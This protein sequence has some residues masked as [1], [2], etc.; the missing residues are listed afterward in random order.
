MVMGNN[1]TRARKLTL[2]VGDKE[3]TDDLAIKILGWWITPDNKL[4][5]HLNKIKGPVFKTIA[6]LKPYLAFID[7]KERR[8]VVYSKAISIAKYG[9]ALF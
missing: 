3:L 8:E 9:L 7:L 5:H 1:T 6:E 4:I 2:K